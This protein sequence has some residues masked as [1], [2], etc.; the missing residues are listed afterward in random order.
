MAH[1][2]LIARRRRAGFNPNPLPASLIAA[3]LAQLRAWDGGAVP[4]A[5][6]ET[7][8][9]AKVWV[10]EVMVSPGLPWVRLE[11]PIGTRE[12]MAGG[13]FIERGQFQVS[14]FAAGSLQAQ[15]IAD[16]IAKTAP[17]DA[18]GALDNPPLVWRT[19]KLMKFVTRTTSFPVPDSP[20]V[21]SAVAFQ[22]VLLF[23]YWYSGS[24]S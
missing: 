20:A 10:G 2:I 14:V 23:D 18:P 6:G 16:L 12:Y 19:G 22:R 21:G 9:V 3:V 11:K 17:G 8:A 24:M 7:G 4:Q 15:T 5:L 13:S 1:N